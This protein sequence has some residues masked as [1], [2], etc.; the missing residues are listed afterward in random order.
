M[1]PLACGNQNNAPTGP[2]GGSAATATFTASPTKTNTPGGPTSTPTPLPA[3]ANTPTFTPT[4]AVVPPTYEH[5]YATSASPNGM[6]IAGGLMTLAEKE[7]TSSGYYALES[8][9]LGNAGVTTNTVPYINDYLLQGIPTPNSTPPWVPVTVTLQGPQGYV[10]P[11][12][13]GPVV[14]P[15]YPVNPSS[16]NSAYA[17]VLDVAPSGSAILYE[18]NDYEDG[19]WAGGPP[20]ALDY[21]SQY[22]PVEVSGYGGIAFNNP[23]AL[24]ADTVGNLYVTDTGNGLVEEFWGYGGPVYPQA[25]LHKSSGNAGITFVNST[26]PANPVTF[27][28]VSFISPYGITCDPNPG[29]TLNDV[30]V[31]DTGYSPSVVQAFSFSGGVSILAAWQTVAG[32]KATGIAI[33]PTGSSIAGDVCIADSG[34]NQVEIYNPAGTLL[35]VLSD[36]HSLYEGGKFFAPSCIGFNA[37]STTYD[38]WVA[39]TNNDFVISFLP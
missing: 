37:A 7:D 16:A 25:G 39:D 20:T 26:A 35:S 5:T 17:A 21:D 1:I 18:G 8:F 22:E 10:N 34:N 3:G 2:I 38:L 6:V 9:S 24:T 19:W 36:P 14:Q 23:K 27:V 13:N 15:N 33:A 28:S 30:W 31:T 4:F 29:P 12:F 11:G 32:C